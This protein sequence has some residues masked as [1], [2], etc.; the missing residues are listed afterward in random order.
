MGDQE[1]ETTVAAEEQVSQ[2]P[3][4]EQQLQD[5]ANE[6]ASATGGQG[7]EVEKP[8]TPART[9]RPRTVPIERLNKIHAEKMHAIKQ[10]EELKSEV[11]KLRGSQPAAPAP[12]GMNADDIGMTPEDLA[13]FQ[14]N[15]AKA[16][17]RIAERKAEKVARDEVNKVAE[18]QNKRHEHLVALQ[19]LSR[20]KIA[21]TDP[22]FAPTIER[23]VKENPGLQNLE[24]E[25]AAKALLGLYAAEY[26]EGQAEEEAKTPG[27]A[28]ATPQEVKRGLRP[29]G[30]PP[31][32]PRGARTPEEIRN[33]PDA[34]WEKERVK[35]G[36]GL[37]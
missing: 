21:K 11:E 18:A 23:L 1:L 35:W 26:I 12:A 29:G 16:V 10:L 33:M 7:T 17:A 6:S 8:A 4:A 37:H 19:G 32:A 22:Q 31:P 14:I 2:P 5:P 24:P 25:A 36:F 15:P 28:R 30:T 34:E 13:E 20:L 3:E 9:D 27:A